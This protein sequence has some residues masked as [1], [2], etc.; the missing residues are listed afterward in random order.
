MAT[1]K[2]LLQDLD[3]LP[4]DSLNHL[5]AGERE[6][7]ADM[8]RPEDAW[9]K[10][11][12]RAWLREE[13]GRALNM[14][15]ASVPLQHRPSGKPAVAAPLAFNLSH[16]GPWAALVMLEEP[17]RHACSG[18]GVDLETP[19]QAEGLWAARHQFLHP[20]EMRD[21]ECMETE[22]RD[23]LCLLGWTRKEAVLKA[24]GAGLM[25]ADLPPS[26]LQ[27]GAHPGRCV[28]HAP[29]GTGA[30]PACHVVSHTGAAVMLSV[31][32]QGEAD[33]HVQWP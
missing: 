30:W 23:R 8:R 6:L 9:R 7:A 27:V 3:R 2:V 17:Q 5:H 18:V 22:H 15:P 28:V 4:P 29:Q 10:A 14:A 26:A 25:V 31:A 21:L 32:W 20:S 1:L 13:L 24:W 12:A 33:L 19:S 11:A 16:S